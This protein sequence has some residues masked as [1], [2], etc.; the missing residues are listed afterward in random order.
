M[1]QNTSQSF[2][3]PDEY[4]DHLIDPDCTCGHLA[5]DHLSVGCWGTKA[6]TCDRDEID[7]N[8]AAVDKLIRDKIA[9][10]L[11]EQ[12]RYVQGLM[13]RQ[14]TLHGGKLATWDVLAEV[15]TALEER[16]KEIR[17]G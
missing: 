9:A 16:S 7:V 3:T 1:S 14:E 4:R 6:C 12:A 10:E 15:L 2:V 11:T 8:I 17:N 13:D 5:T